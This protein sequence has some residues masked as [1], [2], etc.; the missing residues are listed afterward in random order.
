MNIWKRQVVYEAVNKILINFEIVVSNHNSTCIPVDT[1]P[2]NSNA[3]SEADVLQI[4]LL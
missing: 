4:A 2:E 3:N 1:E